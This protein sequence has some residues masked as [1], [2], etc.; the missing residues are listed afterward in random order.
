MKQKKT[1][2]NKM[3]LAF[4]AGLLSMTQ[5]QA[6]SEIY[7]QHFDLGEVTLLDGPFKTAMDTNI[8]LLLQYDVDRLLTP[9]IRQSGLSK[10]TTSKYYQWENSHPTFSNWGLS[11]WSLEGHV[12][13]HYLTALALA[14]SAERDNTLKAALKQRLDYMIEDSWADSL[15]TRYGPDSTRETSPNS[16]S[17][18]DGC[19][20]IASTRCWQVFVMPGSMPEIQKPRPC[21]RT[22]ATG[23]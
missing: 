1:L 13:G 20:C 21:I 22:C 4:A 9:F 3:F 18:A 6:Q 7:P 12:G 16:R 23:P 14:Y 5:A 19:H 8:N 17:M 11:S 10:V 15:S 2:G